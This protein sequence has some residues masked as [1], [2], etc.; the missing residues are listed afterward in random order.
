M[1]K[2]LQEK[3]DGLRTQVNG[4]QEQISNYKRDLQQLNNDKEDMIV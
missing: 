3:I 4:Q 2:E 1:E